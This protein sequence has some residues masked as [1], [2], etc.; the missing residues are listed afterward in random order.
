MSQVR[1]KSKLL[2]F[3]SKMHKSNLW[4]TEFPLIWLVWSD[5]PK[6]WD[7]RAQRHAWWLSLFCIPESPS[8]LLS[9][10]NWHQW[11]SDPPRDQQ[12]WLLLLPSWGHWVHRIHCKWNPH[13]TNNKTSRI[14]WCN[15]EMSRKCWPHGWIWVPK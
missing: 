10:R 7:N 9:C 14:Q 8:L 4:L 2:I 12:L 1:R 5:P 13:N 11:H 6:F 3:T 15:L